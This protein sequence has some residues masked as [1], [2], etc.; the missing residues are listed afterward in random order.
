MPNADRNVCVT[1]NFLSKVD[2]AIALSLD[3]KSE[4]AMELEA[5]SASVVER[6]PGSGPD[7][8]AAAHEKSKC[9]TLCLVPPARPDK[10]AA[11][12]ELVESRARRRLRQQRTP[13]QLG[14]RRLRRARDAAAAVRIYRSR[15]HGFDDRHRGQTMA[16]TGRMLASGKELTAAASK[17]VGVEL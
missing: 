6:E 8:V 1:G 7:G 12:T 2:S 5:L 10:L 13:H 9:D 11:C 14:L 4:K 17:G 16:V 15:G 3:A